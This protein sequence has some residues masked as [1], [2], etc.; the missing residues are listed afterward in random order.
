MH[1]L[2][3]A[4]IVFVCTAAN[5]LGLIQA[6]LTV[7]KRHDLPI[8]SCVKCLTF[9]CVLG[10]GCYGIATYGTEIITVLAISF[11]SAWLSIWLDLLMGIIDKLYLRIYESLYPTADTT[12]DDAIGATDSV[13]D[14]SDEEGC[15]DIA[16]NGTNGTEGKENNHKK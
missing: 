3:I 8:V 5:H 15:D 10:Y 7:T 11:L 6:I 16:T 1:L 2:D 9:W 4:C 13:P 12:D 14:V